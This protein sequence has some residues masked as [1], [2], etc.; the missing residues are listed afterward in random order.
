[1]LNELDRK[2]QQLIK[3]L[4][5]NARTAVSSLA[6]QLNLSR[7]AVHERIKKLELSGVIQGYTV[8]LNRNTEAHSIR[9]Q[10]MI[11][12]APQFNAKVATAL[13]ALDAV[14][15]LHAVSGVFD[16]LASI[17][18]N[19]TNEVDEVL[20]RIGAIEGVER[21]QSAILLSTKFER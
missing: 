5:T 19:S 12:V 13:R 17:R 8:R 15:S 3:L 16:L 20:D 2:N 18:A 11:S 9:A 10:V 21:T 7:T 14:E 1:M 6:K 4:R